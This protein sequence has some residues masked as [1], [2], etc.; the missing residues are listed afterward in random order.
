MD[1][2]MLFRFHQDAVAKIK[3]HGHLVLVVG[4]DHERQEPGFSYTVGLQES[5]GVELFL[6][7][8]P[9]QAAHIILNEIAY[10][11]QQEG[12]DLTQPARLENF[13]ANELPIGLIVARDE[14]KDTHTVQAGE[15]F[16]NQEYRVM[17]CVVPDPDG[18]FP[19]DIGCRHETIIFQTVRGPI[20]ELP[21]PLR[22]LTCPE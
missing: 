9:H 16:G 22:V 17:Q 6:E 8:V 2:D 11:A 19:W 7:G 21:K 18:R 4:P 12:W 14:I 20:D 5:L 3:E 15:I 1:Q 10:V 13:A